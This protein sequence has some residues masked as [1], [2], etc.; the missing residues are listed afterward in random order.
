MVC[1]S[2]NHPSRFTNKE[3]TATYIDIALGWDP[4]ADG[5]HKWLQQLR[6]LLPKLQQKYHV[7]LY[8]DWLQ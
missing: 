6:S 3:K 5:G 2:T 1:V 7:E 4:I 8:V